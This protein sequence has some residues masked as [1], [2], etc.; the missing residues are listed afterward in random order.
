[1]PEK[2]YKAS[3][4]QTFS[5]SAHIL[6]ETQIETKRWWYGTVQSQNMMSF[7]RNVFCK[8]WIQ[9]SDS[10]ES[11]RFEL[12]M[13]HCAASISYFSV[14]CVW[15]VITTILLERLKMSELWNYR[16][17]QRMNTTRTRTFTFILHLTK[18]NSNYCFIIALKTFCCGHKQLN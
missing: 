5:S 1:M 8:Y 7:V 18:R 16:S 10:F 17:D 4:L 12:L 15:W 6:S 14:F 2:R 3:N 9:E 13:L 11:S